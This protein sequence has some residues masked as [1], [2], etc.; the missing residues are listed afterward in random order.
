MQVL[1]VRLEPR[2]DAAGTELAPAVDDHEAIGAILRERAQYA[3]WHSAALQ[4]QAF[5]ACR[6]ASRRLPCFAYDLDLAALGIGAKRRGAKSF[7]LTS[8]ERL[9]RRQLA[10]LP[11]ERRYYETL[12]DDLW[13][14]LY[15]DLDMCQQTNPGVDGH[16]LCEQIQVYL[17]QFLAESYPAIFS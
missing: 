6:P 15:L 5:D 2:C 16:A 8:Y 7:V 17:R 1:S 9:F 13:C 3:G 4:Q 14:H 11:E 10:H 12:F